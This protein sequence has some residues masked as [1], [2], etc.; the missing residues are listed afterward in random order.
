MITTTR[1]AI[2]ILKRPIFNLIDRFTFRENRFSKLF[3]ETA[4]WTVKQLKNYQLMKLSKEKK[5]WFCILG[6]PKSM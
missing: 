2:N 3:A 1:S 4:T 6:E 5:N